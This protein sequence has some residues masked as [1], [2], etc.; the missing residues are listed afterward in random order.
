MKRF[1][2]IASALCAALL[3][4]WYC[5][6]SV[7]RMLHAPSGTDPAKLDA[8]PALTVSDVRVQLVRTGSDERL[9][10]YVES[11]QT[12]RLFGLVPLRI[13]HTNGMPAS[14]NIG[15]EAVGVV[16][17]TEG[18]QIVGLGAIDTENGRRSP[19]ADAGLLEGDMILSVN[20]SAVDSTATFMQLCESSDGVCTLNCLRK[21]QRFTVT[22]QPERDSDGALRIGAWVRDSTS[23]I[24]T[25]SFYDANTRAYAALGHGVTD[26]DTGR[27]LSPATGILTQ[28]TVTAVR[29]G[30]ANEAGEL[31]GSFSSRERDAIASIER[32][33]EF[34]IAGTLTAF[35]DPSAQTFQIAPSDAVHLGDAY[36]CS[37]VEGNTVKPYSVRVI[38]V[39]VQS[40]PSIQGMMI[41]ITDPTLLSL[42]GGIVQGMSG[43]P[44]IQDGRLIGVVTH[45]FVSHPTRGY[46]LYAEWM[47]KELLP[48]T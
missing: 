13:F 28:A 30:S 36:I 26:V 45:V 8:A 2:R 14:V 31:L 20:G 33:T 48:S 15:G 22:V 18:V 1:F 23:G 17:H 32:N 3:L 25:L 35:S 39:D 41:E 10:Q 9:S 7:Y 5:N 42:T 11:R 19:A 47:A 46:C 12:L 6:P 4:L 21:D 43:S 29:K 16:L 27:L 37:T 40:A 44:L 24:G 34:G 38:R